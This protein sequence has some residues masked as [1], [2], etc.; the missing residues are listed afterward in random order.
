MGDVR[1]WSR[2]RAP[3]AA[4]PSAGGNS[5]RH[6]RSRRKLRPFALR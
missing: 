1:N 6:S 5:G 3:Q 4:A 2:H